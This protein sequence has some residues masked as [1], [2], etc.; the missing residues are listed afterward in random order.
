MGVCHRRTGL[1]LQKKNQSKIPILCTQIKLDHFPKW[2]FPEIRVP[3]NGWF[4]MENPIKID[5]LG[6]PL[7]LEGHPNR[8]ENKKIF[9]TTWNHHLHRWCD[10][11][12]ASWWY[13]L[14]NWAKQAEK[15]VDGSGKVLKGA[16]QTTLH[17]PYQW[18]IVVLVRG[19]RDYITP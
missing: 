17:K 16:N 5:N 7:F 3:Q 2:V 14:L 13:D 11:M 6:V 8:D 18:M 1:F 4:I 9:E 10:V 15:T 19:G 12:I